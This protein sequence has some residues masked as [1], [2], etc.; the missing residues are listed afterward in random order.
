MDFRHYSLRIA[1]PLGLMVFVV[2]LLTAAYFDTVISSRGR[3]QRLAEDDILMD[4]ER[5][6]RTA[7]RE[8]KNDPAH[9][10]SDIAF[11]AMEPRAKIVAL[12]T[13]KGEVQFANRMAWQG[14]M[15]SQVIPDFSAERF[16]HARQGRQPNVETSPSGNQVKA[17]M[18]YT[19]ESGTYQLR[20]EQRGVIYMEYDLEYDFA[21]ATWEARR[22]ML[23]LVSVA[24]LMALLLFL[25]I[26]KRVTLPLERIEAA[27]LELARG[28][29]VPAPLPEKGSKEVAQLAKGFNFMVQRL[30]LA[31]HDLET[32]NARLNAIF[33][34]AM[35]AIITVDSNHRIL[36]INEA[37]LAMFQVEEEKV[38]G[39]LIE[40]LLPERFRQSHG[41]Y[42]QQFAKSDGKAKAMG[43]TTVV[44]GL[45]SNGEEFPV[46]ASISHVNVDGEVL[47]TVIL[48]DVTERHRDQL[49][50][51]Q[52][53]ADLEDQVKLRTAKLLET[54]RALEQQQHVLRAAHDEQRTIFDTVTVGIALM[55]DRT[56]IRCN[57]K[58]EDIFGYSPGELDGTSTRIWYSSDKEYEDAGNSVIPNIATGN[59]HYREKQLRRK[60]G[61]PLWIRF[62]GSQFDNAQS[63]GAILGVFE[64]MTL[65][66]EAEVAIL[67]AKKKAE[68][69][70]QAKSSFLANMSHEIRTPMN[71]I[72]GMS[73]LVLKGE[74]LPRQRDQIRKIQSSS[75][76]LLG[77]INDI[78][79]YS[80]IEAGK[81]AI[82]HIDF[83]LDRVLENVASLISEKASA[84][85]L[86]LIFD[87]DRGVPQ[88]LVGDPLRLGQVLINYANNAV[89]FTSK[90][91]VNV[92]IKVQH[93]TDNEV[94][95]YCAV[96]DTGIGL[97]DEQIS[98]LFESFQ[99]ADGST[100]REFG[101]TGLGLAICKQ[102]AS[103]M[104]GEVGV[105][106]EYGVGSTFWF[107]ARLAK[108]TNL[109]R[110]Q[111]LRSELYGKRV[112]VVD[113]N[114]S[115][116][117][118]L[119]DMLAALNLS[120]LAVDSGTA[121]LD[122]IYR[123]DDAGLPFEIAFIDW[124]M[125]HM[126]GVELA[127]R[128][129]ALPIAAQPGIV[130]VTGYGREEVL[131]S[132]Q[133]AG[134]H[135]VLVKPVNASM[136]FDCVVRELDDNRNTGDS[137]AAGQ[138]I[139]HALDAIRGAR[140]LLV[141]D[142]ELNREVAT[143][144]LRDAGLHVEQAFNGQMAIDRLQS[145]RYDMVLMDMQMPV[146]DGLTATRLLRE[147]PQFADL[148]IVAMTANAM[149][150]DRQACL[151]AGMND[152]VPK[153]IE[154]DQLFRSL[155]QWIPVQT[156]AS[157]VALQPRSEQDNVDIP[158]IPGLDSASGLRRVIGKKN[159]YL[160]LLQKFGAEQRS[161]ANDIRTALASDDW[162]AAE[163]RVHTLKGL[164][165]SIGMTA[166]QNR[167]TELE[168]AVRQRMAPMQIE[169]LLSALSQV[170][171]P[172]V[173]ALEAALPGTGRPVAAKAT[174]VAA[175]AAVC[176]RLMSL[177]SQDDLEANDLFNENTA[178]LHQALGPWFAP[179]QA[180]VQ[181]FD[182][183]A[184]IEQLQAAATAL[185]ISLV[186]QGGRG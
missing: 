123:A 120:V 30:Q 139:E 42:M 2:L 75:Q 142:N 147:M 60:D 112:L 84:K 71:A 100:T 93:E 79:D 25:L 66:H 36:V 13:S 78:L 116:R 83:E 127:A 58:L 125:P 171:T 151:A 161:A 41:H 38:L 44:Y 40:S 135:N 23:P 105:Q 134:I 3:V 48:R 124:Q 61:T 89:K 67:E 186:P 136:L 57:R 8:L 43:R 179:L 86:E 117:Y 91:E 29:A 182:C 126:T 172:F 108:S 51:Q 12:I 33:D 70:S 146:V 148:P 47:L 140:I 90:G 26:R 180:A 152:H 59:V 141:E 118:M 62:T 98:R 166:I 107:T 10:A 18:S 20:T 35:D 109:A 28:N 143:E 99:Q 101:G 156:D 163:R 95:L 16:L 68:E 74:L 69:A 77:I 27:H 150:S 185:H 153:P 168:A 155:L 22:R 128:I 122:A 114:D 160:T 76:H 46:E 129:H 173:D 72:I 97:T 174:D 183:D 63:G 37:A 119:R 9:I 184:A 138:P 177:L 39:E 4:A 45:R 103:L 149:E 31:Q 154:P 21:V 165:G 110:P 7:Q 14:H 157:P 102:L 1:I 178:I 32:S 85:G 111:V 132:A 65:Q 81:L 92:H 50:L 11:A 55:K 82:E 175:V 176:C 96:K 130:L 5:L 167:A 169:P 104:H 15:A 53:K 115:A 170:L 181:N 54:T 49:A 162:P 80:K 164:A 19:E 64:D 34:A 56:I 144:L 88:L 52:A 158:E 87:V 159:L 113:D 121:A 6:A 133:E 17:M 73:Y 137:P 24:M 145:E 131:N 106:S 94:I